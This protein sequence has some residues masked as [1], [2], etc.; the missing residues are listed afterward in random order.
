MGRE[1]KREDN[2][3]YVVFNEKT[4]QFIPVKNGAVLETIIIPPATKLEK[5]AGN[6][7]EYD[8]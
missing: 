1:L 4:K 8:Y 2:W 3:E 7:S 5:K 6:I